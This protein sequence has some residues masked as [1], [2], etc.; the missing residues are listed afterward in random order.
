MTHPMTLEVSTHW[1]IPGTFPRLLIREG[2]SWGVAG[3]LKAFCIKTRESKPHQSTWARYLG[4]FKNDKCFEWKYGWEKHAR[5]SLKG[6]NQNGRGKTVWGEVGEIEKLISA[7]GGRLFRIVSD[8]ASQAVVLVWLSVAILH[9]IATFLLFLAFTDQRKMF[10]GGGGGGV[11]LLVV[12]LTNFLG[13][14]L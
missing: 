8:V 11:T 7:P 1:T 5:K 13:Y 12:H 4:A 9:E 6:A 2:G 3:I 14:D 10:G